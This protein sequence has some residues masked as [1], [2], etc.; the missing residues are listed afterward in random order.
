MPVAKRSETSSELTL[1]FYHTSL[2]TASCLP[3]YL[4]EIVRQGG[5]DGVE[6]GKRNFTTEY[7]TSQVERR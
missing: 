1:L 6:A 5:A 2:K 3:K 4:V 7:F